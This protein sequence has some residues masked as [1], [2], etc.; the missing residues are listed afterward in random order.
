M[1]CAIMK[2]L[3][4]SAIIMGPMVGILTEA[5]LLDFFI[6]MVGRN[7]M[8]FILGSITAVLSALVHKIFTIILLYGFN[9]VK[10]LENMY[11]FAQKQLKVTGPEP[12]TLIIFLAGFYLFFGLLAAVIGMLAGNNLGK[13]NKNVK[14]D[15]HGSENQ[16]LMD[17]GKDNYSLGLLFFHVLAL[18]VSLYLINRVNLVVSFVI[19]LPYI[20]FIFYKYKKALRR[21]AKPLFWLQLVFILFFAVVFWSEVPVNGLPESEGFIVGLKMIFRAVIVV[22]VFSAISVELRNPVVKTVLYKKGFSHFY[23]SLSLAFSVLPGVMSRITKPL[24]IILHPINSLSDTILYSEQLYQDFKSRI[25]KKQAVF[26]IAGNEREGKTTFLFKTIKLLKESG[27]QVEGIMAEGMD[28]DGQRIGF[29]LVDV[30]DEERKIV[31]CSIDGKENWEKT[32]RYYFNPAGLKFGRDI[33][34]D[35]STN[36]IIVIDEI[37]PLEINGGGWSD[38]IEKILSK[39]DNPMIWVV[40]RKLTE[41]IIHKFDLENVSIMDIKFYQPEELV[42]YVYSARH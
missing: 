4:P 10:I 11:Q 31:L 38:S 17:L 3:S 26:I 23:S 37:G 15:L 9:I 1:I 13:Q 24:S 42:E 16:E 21:L 18:I 2:S 29:H 19:I 41:Q 8:G 30:R 7:P 33:L 27:K 14:I 34:S 40:R 6:R 5:F 32:G 20:I 22:M 39:Y 25:A 36:S 12:L 28:V 35:I